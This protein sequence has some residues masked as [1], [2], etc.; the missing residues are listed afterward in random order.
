MR[1]RIYDKMW[2]FQAKRILAVTNF[3]ET[4]RGFMKN[5]QRY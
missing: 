2:I 4:S 1:G 3:G 5:N